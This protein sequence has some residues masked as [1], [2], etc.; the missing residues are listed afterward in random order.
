MA[1]SG[2]LS[3][4]SIIQILNLVNLAQKTGALVIKHAELQSVMAFRNGRLIYAHYGGEDDSLVGV[5]FRAKKLTRAQA[6]LIHQRAA[7][8]SDKQLGLMLINAGYLSQADI[9]A[10][11]QEYYVSVSSARWTGALNF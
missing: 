2:N 3:D 6:Q 5:L 7:N 11:L 10:C 1:L 4:F 9:L 8:I